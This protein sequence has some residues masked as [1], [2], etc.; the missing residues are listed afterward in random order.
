[1]RSPALSSGA[2]SPQTAP[3]IKHHKDNISFID[4]VGAN[5]KPKDA[6]SLKSGQSSDTSIFS[7]RTDKPSKREE[8]QRKTE[9]KK[10]KK[11]EAK[12]RTERLAVELKEKAKQ[13][14]AA[15]ERTSIHSG[16]S[17]DGRPQWVDGPS[18][19]GALG[20]L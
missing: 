4:F 6:P 20:S 10:R 15:L 18:M 5:A 2:V 17:S 19:F 11:A 8:K 7:F 1:L 3:V 13:R 14:A 9:E 16:R 12:A